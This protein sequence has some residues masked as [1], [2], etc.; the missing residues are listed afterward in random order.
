MVWT[1]PWRVFIWRQTPL[2]TSLARSYYSG[3]P[4]YKT[5]YVY[6]DRG[7]KIFHINTTKRA[8]PSRRARHFG[9]NVLFI[10]YLNPQQK[11]VVTDIKM[12]GPFARASPPDKL[13]CKMGKKTSPS[14][15]AS[16]PSRARR[17]HIN[18]A[19]NQ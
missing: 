16:P 14:K 10:N 12:S 17:F 1:D 3:H 13:P 6:M 4:S 19:L 5:F 18:T 2:E 11:E 7:L 8:S 15:R 9:A